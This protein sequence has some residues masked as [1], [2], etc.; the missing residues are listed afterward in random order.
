MEKIIELFE[1]QVNVTTTAFPS[2]FSKDDVINL[3]LELKDNVLTE[4]AAT[5][6]AQTFTKETILA[7][8]EEV[9]DNAPY[10]EFMECEPELHGGYGDSYSL[11]M[12]YRFDER[13]FARMVVSELEDYFTK[14]Y[15]EL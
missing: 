11:E 9:L 1:N 2:I 13:E 6:A 14:I 15:Q 3:L 5:K 4:L 12:N 7:A 10:D 8:A